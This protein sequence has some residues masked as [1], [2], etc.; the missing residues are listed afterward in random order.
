MTDRQRFPLDETPLS[1]LRIFRAVVDAE[2]Y[3]AAARHMKVSV[4]SVSK[5]VSALERALGAALLFRTTRKVSVTEAGLR[6]YEH[7]LTI[8]KEVDSVA[9]A[10]A[11]GMRGHL[12]ISAPPSVASELLGPGL[13]SFL[14][15]HPHL[16]VDL[17]VTSALPDIVKDRIDVALV[18]RGWPEVKM[19]NRLVARLS[20]VLCASPGYLE[21]KGAPATASD[22]LQHTCLVSLIGGKADPWVLGRGGRRTAVPID[23]VLSCDNGDMLRSACV[24]GM[25]IANLYEFYARRDLVSGTLVRVL[26]QDQQ[27]PVGLYAILPHREIVRSPASALLDH[28]ESLVSEHER[29]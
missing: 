22:L 3:S 27:D 25:G 9:V 26:P 23:P 15:A 13:R 1:A 14:A 19:A 4:S 16:K 17:F 6:F 24:A 12:R 8:L 10:Q 11:D 7:C 21:E 18:L 29:V 20:R 2:G 5:T 28:L